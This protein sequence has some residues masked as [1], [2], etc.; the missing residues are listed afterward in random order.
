MPKLPHFKHL[1]NL[2]AKGVVRLYKLRSVIDGSEQ[3]FVD[4]GPFETNPDFQRLDPSGGRQNLIRTLR[5]LDAEDGMPIWFADSP[6]QKPVY[7]AASGQF[8]PIPVVDKARVE[9]LERNLRARKEMSR[10]GAQ[11]LKSAR[12]A[13]AIEEAKKSASGVITNV[14]TAVDVQIAANAGVGPAPQVQQ[15]SEPADAAALAR[16]QAAGQGVEA[17]TG[18]AA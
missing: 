13:L 9:K 11:V 2:E 14:Q 18:G 16:I 12:D 17:P 5:K 3:T 4:E 15:T 10:T 6:G 7:D 1:Q 8:I